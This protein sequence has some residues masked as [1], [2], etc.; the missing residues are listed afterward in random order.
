M[1][2]GDKMGVCDFHSHTILTD[3][4]LLPTEQIRR[5]AVNGL[6]AIALTDHV[7]VGNYADVLRTLIPD[8]EMVR[9]YWDIIAIPGV[10]ITHAPADS[11][12]DL[13]RRAKEA[14]AKIVVVHGETTA[15]PV[16]PGTN[17]AA[18]QS[19]DV[20]LLAHPGFITLN[21]AA[22]A[23][24]NGTF[25]EISC[26]KG[27]SITNGHVV[28]VGR[29]AGVKFLIDTDAHTVPDLLTEAMARRVGAGAG[30]DEEELEV[31]LF[32]NS[33]L[34]LQHLGFAT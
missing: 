1:H 19:P 28:K 34:M 7:D 15:E 29:A 16:E 33:K 31:V 13:A 24:A 25:V 21:E 2:E 17:L 9:R 5:A 12:A 20:D 3:G 27:H 26:R 18:I 22:L 6:S 11:I 30:L 32:E 8:C 4:E 23:A 10:E 14:G